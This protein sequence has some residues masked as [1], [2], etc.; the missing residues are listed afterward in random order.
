MR[1]EC[2]SAASFSEISVKRAAILGLHEPQF[3]S[4]PN[5]A[6]TA[7]TG[8]K[9]CSWAARKMVLTPVPT[10]EHKM[11]PVLGRSTGGGR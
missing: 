1:G 10:H 6:S 9:P 8:I 2:H 3:V 4:A 7:Y 5:A 11:G